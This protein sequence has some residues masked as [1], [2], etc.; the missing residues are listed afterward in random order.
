MGKKCEGG[1]LRTLARVFELL[2]FLFYSNNIYASVTVG[3][4]TSFYHHGLG[5]VINGKTVIGRNCN[6]FQNVTI[7]SRWKDGECQGE[8]PVI[9]DNVLIG[10]G[11]VILGDIKV[12]NN[13]RIGANA[14]VIK[15]VPD[16]CT[17]VGNPASIYRKG[18]EI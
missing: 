5:C 14:V 7:G 13:V 6:V 15:D 10:A 9:G 16:N 8:S 2:S 18:K 4:G 12:G 3:E 11:A 1:V 17:V